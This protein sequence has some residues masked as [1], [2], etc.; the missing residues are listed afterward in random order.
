MRDITV[1]FVF[2]LSVPNILHAPDI[3]FV[4]SSSDD[5]LSDISD[6]VFDHVGYSYSID[7][8]A[9]TKIRSMFSHLIDR[10]FEK[11]CYKYY[12]R[13]FLQLHSDIN[14]Q[15][16]FAI[17][18]KQECFNQIWINAFFVFLHCFLCSSY[19][20]I[21][22][23]GMKS[24]FERIY[25]QC[26]LC[27]IKIM[28]IQDNI[29]LQFMKF[30]KQLKVLHRELMFIESCILKKD[31][32]AFC[33]VKEIRKARR[34]FIKA[35]D[36]TSLERTEFFKIEY[37][38]LKQGRREDKK[39]CRIKEELIRVAPDSMSMIEW[40]TDGE[41]EE[42]TG[43]VGADSVSVVEQKPCGE[44]ELSQDQGEESMG[45]G[46]DLASVIE[47]EVRRES[48]CEKIEDMLSDLYDG[49]CDCLGI[50]E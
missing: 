8:R 30:R 28:E 34:N 1:F 46:P 9:V 38:E 21:E 40:G 17:S 7:K 32:Y 45:S 36:Q 16:D 37:K 39:I 2:Y 26:L 47:P 25:E 41:D 23:K 14:P 5:A 19:C 50:S 3:Y 4:S 33:N 22:S 20:F 15:Q 31:L 27:M 29:P 10:V 43:F 12:S 18:V 49:F 13:Y 35:F 48:F 6:I 44:V 24:D 11:V 42:P